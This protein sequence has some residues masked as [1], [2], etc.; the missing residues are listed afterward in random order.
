MKLSQGEDREGQCGCQGVGPGLSS[1]HGCAVPPA[2]LGGS[3]AA[4][5]AGKDV[6]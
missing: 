6:C 2:A 1:M 5:W 4:V 3:A